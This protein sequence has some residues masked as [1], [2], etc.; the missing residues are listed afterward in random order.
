MRHTLLLLVFASCAQREAGI[1]VEVSLTVATMPTGGPRLDVGRLSITSV[2]GVP[3]DELMASLNP[4][5]SAWAHGAH[6][7]EAASPLRADLAVD[8]DLLTPGVTP[9]ATL[10]PPPGLWCALEL[11]FSPSSSDAMWGGA[12]F[13]VDASDGAANRRYLSTSQRVPQLRFLPLTLS[14]TAR[15]HHLTIGLDPT[16]LSTLRPATSDT[17]LELLDTLS[18]SVT[19]STVETLK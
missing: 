5:S 6:T 3:C 7:S 18:S 11:R 8:V 4:I 9:L 19:L 10:R 17:R 16:V 15:H 1:E 13:L 12:T 2:R 14:D